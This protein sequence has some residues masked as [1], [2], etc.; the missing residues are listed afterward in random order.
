[1]NSWEKLV[2]RWARFPSLLELNLRLTETLE[3]LLTFN[4]IPPHKFETYLDHSVETLS[5]TNTS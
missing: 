2:Q 3:E 5:I 1:M 4:Y